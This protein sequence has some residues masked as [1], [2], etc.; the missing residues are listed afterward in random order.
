MATTTMESGGSSVGKE[1]FL[2]FSGMASEMMVRMHLQP[3]F[4]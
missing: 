1:R 2:P 3:L 4:T